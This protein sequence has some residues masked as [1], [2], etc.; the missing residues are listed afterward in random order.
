MPRRRDETS[1]RETS[2]GIIPRSKL[3]PLEIEGIKRAWDFV[4]QRHSRG[5]IPITS[6]SLLKVH[7]IGFKWIFPDAGGRFRTRD[8]EV[9]NHRPPPYYSVGTLMLDFCLD[10]TERLRHL[11]P[12]NHPDFL[13]TLIEILAWAHHRF[14]WI[15]PFFDYNGRIGR[16]LINI[17][18]LNLDLPP[19]EL[20]IETKIGRKNYIRALQA[21]DRGDH[22]LLQIIIRRALE[23][24]ARNVGR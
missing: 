10:L 13:E 16:L 20:H 14:L 5:K 24:S 22:R 15:H 6:S 12:L 8:V 4:L 18:L 11:P 1:F 17:I 19:I 21:A 23:E 3:I 9:S 7:A 2:F